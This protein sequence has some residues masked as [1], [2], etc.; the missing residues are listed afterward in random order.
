MQK[1]LDNNNELFDLSAEY[2][3]T[4]YVEPLITGNENF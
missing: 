2:Y 1:G 3:A 4:N